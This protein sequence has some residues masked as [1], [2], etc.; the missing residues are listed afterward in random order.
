MEIFKIDE[1]LY[2]SSAIDNPG[3]IRELKIDAII[4]LEGGLDPYLCQELYLHWP[5]E[6]R[7][8]PDLGTLKEVVNF[9]YNLCYRQKKKVLVH[10]AQGI[11]RASLVNGYIIHLKTGLKGQDLINFIREKRPGAL[12]NQNFVDYLLLL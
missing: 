9:G 4:D 12:T 3:K 1:N 8:L 7:D 5:I 6:D 2:Q 10:C 11:N